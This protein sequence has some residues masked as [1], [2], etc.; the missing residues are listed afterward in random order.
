MVLDDANKLNAEAPK[1]SCEFKRKSR[2]KISADVSVNDQL[3]ESNVSFRI[4]NSSRDSCA[5]AKH[6]NK[7]SLSQVGISDAQCC[8][9][10]S[11][12]DEAP[13]IIVCS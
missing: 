13:R 6:N 4:S 1:E 10:E 12:V 5:F 9:Y 2:A 3:V 7:V 8:E 11:S